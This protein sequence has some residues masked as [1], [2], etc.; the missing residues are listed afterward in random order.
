M[1]SRVEAALGKVCVTGL[2]S[3]HGT[4]EAGVAIWTMESILDTYKTSMLY[5]GC[6]G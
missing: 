1:L 6:H 5:M 4:Q 3:Y 2:A